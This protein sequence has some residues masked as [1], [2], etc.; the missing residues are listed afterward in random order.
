MGWGSRKGG[1][2]KKSGVA[3]G[4]QP[5]KKSSQEAEY[6]KAVDARW[7]LNK[8]SVRAYASATG[9][10]FYTGA[11]QTDSDYLSLSRVFE[12]QELHTTELMN[13]LGIALSEAGGAVG[14]GAELHGCRAAGQVCH[15]P[16]RSE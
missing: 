14:M 3:D 6:L 5:S 1:K 10:P 12:R 15:R 2:G 8:A 11:G 13:R 16:S 4:G 7:H 9:S